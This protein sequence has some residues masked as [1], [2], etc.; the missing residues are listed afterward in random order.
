MKDIN[1]IQMNKKRHFLF[2]KLIL[3]FTRENKS[4]YKNP[5]N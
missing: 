5:T 2:S 4:K 1:I 3:V